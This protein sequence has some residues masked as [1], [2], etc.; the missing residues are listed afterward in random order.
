MRAPCSPA[1]L[2]NSAS[3]NLHRE[4]AR[5]QSFENG[6][7]VGFEFIHGLRP[8]RF[9]SFDFLNRHRNQLLHRHELRDRRF[10]T[11]EHDAADVKFARIE[12]FNKPAPP[13][14][15][16]RQS[17]C[18]CV[19][20]P[21]SPQTILAALSRR[22]R[23]RPLRPTHSSLTVLPSASIW[24]I[25]RRVSRTTV[26]LNPPHNPRSDVITTSN[27]VSSLP[28]PAISRGVACVMTRFPESRSQHAGHALAIGPTPFRR[29]PAHGAVC[30]QP[31]FSWPR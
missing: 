1:A 17:R 31:P 6:F 9:G 24:R 19:R 2:S 14:G 26:P 23:S 22:S 25:W 8:I 28:V 16:R 7:L 20:Y 29:F 21:R 13:R 3:V 27:T 30:S 4:V 18:A 15:R 10:E 12:Q 11:V 5:Q